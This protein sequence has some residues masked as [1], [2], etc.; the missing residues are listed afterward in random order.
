MTAARISGNNI[1]VTYN[2]NGGTLEVR[3]TGYLND[4]RCG[5]D[6]G[7][8]PTTAGFTTY[9][10][11]TGAS[12]TAANEVTFTFASA[13]AAGTL[14]MAAHGTYP[15]CRTQTGKDLHVAGGTSGTTNAVYLNPEKRA[16]MVCCSYI[17]AELAPMKPYINIAGVLGDDYIVCT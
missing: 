17:D 3:N 11:P 14:V 8:G 16:S 15:Y 13:P 10:Q 5:H 6:F 1:I 4:F 7:S 9:L 2:V 12:V